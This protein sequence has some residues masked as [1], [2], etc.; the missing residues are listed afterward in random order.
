MAKTLV[1]SDEDMDILCRIIDSFHASV[2]QGNAL[3][4]KTATHENMLT[5]RSIRDTLIVINRDDR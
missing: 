3:A 2:S 5:L 1:L 4:W